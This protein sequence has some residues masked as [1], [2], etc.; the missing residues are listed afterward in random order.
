MVSLTGTNSHNRKLT[1]SV[2]TSAC[3]WLGARARCGD[4]TLGDKTFSRLLLEASRGQLTHTSLKTHTRLARSFQRLLQSRVAP[5]DVAPEALPQ[6]TH[7]AERSLGDPGLPRHP[8]SAPTPPRG[9]LAWP[10]PRTRT[11]QAS[12][13]GA[14]GAHGLPT[15]GR[16]RLLTAPG[17]HGNRSRRT[18]QCACSPAAGARG[19]RTL[20][21]GRGHAPSSGAAC[22]SG[23][24][25]GACV[26]APPLA[27]RQ[28]ESGV[29]VVVVVVRSARRHSPA[30]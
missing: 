28:R 13:G 15:S 20:A 27:C 18:A 23:G 16:G 17:R 24:G 8:R 4:A 3:T 10:P 2:Q 9:V 25:G 7:H 19:A 29:V 21:G 11:P 5:L 14:D 1:A 30:S 12:D 26:T 22:C 6:T